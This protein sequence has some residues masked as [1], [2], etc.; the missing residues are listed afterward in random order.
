E[1]E[2]IIR[3]LAR[4]G[5]N[6]VRLTGGEPLVRKGAV[7]LVSM[8]SKIEGIND[9]TMTTNA[10]LLKK[11]AQELK[12]NGLTRVNVSL[13][14]MDPKVYKELTGG[15][16]LKDVL[17]GIEEAVKIGLTPVRLNSVI[18]K[19]RNIDQIAKI[20]DYASS[21]GQ[22]LRLIECMPM[23]DGMDWE[24]NYL[25]VADVLKREDIMERVDTEAAPRM[26]K[27]AAFFLPLRNGKGEV[28]F[29]S[30]MSKRFCEDCNRLRLTSEGK[31]RACLPSD[32][33]V[34][35]KEAIRRGATDEEILKLVREVISNKAQ[36]GKYNFDD[37]GR[38]RSM[39]DI[40]G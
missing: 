35:L 8:I 25:S 15:G 32:N 29:I 18:M 5:V 1:I 36:E 24:A 7:E 33:D 27:E 31:I 23:R 3:P 28:G 22:T 38:K 9:L 12:D 39:V 4:A 10:V 17:E 20:I 40:G 14:T 37:S 19:D 13:D 21:H 30:P 34:D 16:V 6:K 2:A 26:E 11:Y